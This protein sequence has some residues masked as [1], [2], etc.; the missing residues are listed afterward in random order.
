MATAE[1][2]S[3][4]GGRPAA[5]GPESTRLAIRSLDITPGL[6]GNATVRKGYFILWE[7]TRIQ[8]LSVQ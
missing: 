4:S 3:T 5:V 6:P 2:K 7:G 8:S 1:T